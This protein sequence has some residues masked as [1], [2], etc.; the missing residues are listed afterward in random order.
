MGEQVLTLRGNT[1]LASR[2]RLLGT[3]TVYNL[4]VKGLHNFLVGR[5][6]VVVHN[7]CFQLV[8]DFIIREGKLPD[9]YITK[10]QAFDLGWVPN[11]GN[12]QD[13]APGKWIG[14]DIFHNSEG[15]LPTKPGR[16]WREADINYKGGLRGA[17]RLLYSN[18]G[19]FY[20][21]VDHYQTFT[22]V[23]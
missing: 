10:Q 14:G 2:Q 4:E 20:K 15:K 6:G 8:K 3:H 7:S 17:E 9:H 13:I 18:D 5:Q 19:L 11:Q 1:A 23:D 21:T 22:I 12:L 16:V